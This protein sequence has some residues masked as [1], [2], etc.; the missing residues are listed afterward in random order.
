M[1]EASPWKPQPAGASLQERKSGGSP[2]HGSE[3][4]SE[5]GWDLAGK[6]PG[7]IRTAPGTAYTRHGGKAK[8]EMPCTMVPLKTF[9]GGIPNVWRYRQVLQ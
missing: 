7:R 2:T 6:G 8:L 1:G 4:G 9:D 3:A 5:L